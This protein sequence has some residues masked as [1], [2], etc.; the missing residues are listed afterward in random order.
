[1]VSQNFFDALFDK[2]WTPVILLLIVLPAGAGATWWTVWRTDYEMREQLL[3]QARRIVQTVNTRD[4]RAL[5]GT[6]ADLESPTY[7]RLKALLITL[8]QADDRCR[9]IYLMGRQTNGTVFLFVDSE[10]PGSKDYSP[11]G[12]VYDEAGTIEAGVFE[13]GKPIVYGPTKDRWGVWISAYVPIHD[14]R[15]DTVAAMLGIDVDARVWNRDLARAAGMPVATT[16]VLVAILI[17]AAGFASRRRR[18]AAA[19]GPWLQYLEANVVLVAGLVLTLFAAWTAYKIDS[20]HRTHIFENLAESET[21]R[22][23]DAFLDLQHAELEGFARFYENSE[24][25]TK[26]EF[27]R[28]T[29]PLVENSAAYAWGW[30]PAVPAADKEAF[31]QQVRREGFDR[32]EIWELGERGT[33]VATEDREVYFPVLRIARRDGNTDAL[34]FDV[35]SETIR[36]SAMTQ[37]IRTGLCTAT[38]PL[39]LVEEPDDQTAMILFRPVFAAGTEQPLMGFAV[40]IIHLDTLLTCVQD[41]ASVHLTL[42]H[43]GK[44]N[45]I[46]PL[47]SFCDLDPS[48]F[49]AALIVSRPISMHG[50]VLKVVAHPGP[51]F[52]SRYPPYRAAANYF[53]AGLLLTL[54]SLALV[55]RPVQQRRRLEELVSQR[56]AALRKIEARY[57][58]V[59][60]QSRTFTWEIDAEGLYTYVS[61]SVEAILGYRPEELTGQKR[62]FELWP[63]TN[64]DKKWEK[65]LQIRKAKCEFRD[66]ENQAVCRDG[67][68]LWMSTN[69]IPLLDADGNL[70][71]YRGTDSDITHR[72]QFEAERKRLLTES[73]TARAELLNTLEERKRA[74]A[75][76]AR[77]ASAV[78]Q[79][80]EMVVITDSN[81]TICY[82]NP[83]FTRVTGYTREEALGQNPRILKSG[84]HDLAYY[85]QLWDT[86]SG[87]KTW[88]GRLV[89]K[90]KDGT[91]YTE[92]ATISP[93]RDKTGRIV[94]YVAVKRDITEHLKAAQENARLEERLQQMQR[95][96][97]IGRLAGGVAHDFNNMLSV[98]LGYGEELF[99]RLPADD[100]LRENAKQIVQAGQRSATLTGQ[101]LAFS[102]RQTLQPRVLD[103]NALLTNLEPMLRRLIGEDIEIRITCCSDLYLVMADPAQIEHVVVNLA[104]NAQDSMA[105]GGTLMIETAN[106]FLDA[107][108]ALVYGE[109]ASG[110]YAMLSIRDTGC[111]MDRETLAQIFEPFFTT[112]EKGRGTGLG[113]ASAYG[114]TRQSGGQITAESEPGK[115]SVFRIYLPRTLAK[116]TVHPDPPKT[117]SSRGMGEHILVVE[118]EESLRTW[119]V[120]EL[121]ERGYRT[122]EAVDGQ[123]ALRLVQQE[124]LRPDLL[125]TDVIMPGITGTEL[126]TRLRPEHPELKVLF[127]SGYSDDLIR[128]HGV[129]EPGIQFLSK[130]FQRDDLARKVRE[131]LHRRIEPP[132]G[133]RILMIDDEPLFRELIG[134]HCSQ[135]GHEFTGVDAAPAALEALSAREFDVLLLDKNLPGSDGYR[136]LQEIREVGHGLPVILLTGDLASV[137]L[138]TFHALGVI[139]AVEKSGNNKSLLDWIEDRLL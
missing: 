2:I 61:P 82:A 28:F 136:I 30:I 115:G 15:T 3:G 75:E 76:L 31:E 92:D 101:L 73:E 1:M 25:V 23:A 113:L 35:G 53:V 65:A 110:E 60:E 38:P 89:N 135:R 95:V 108:H 13:T 36:R 55:A 88:E 133:K 116:P 81:G 119:V 45:E 127:M 44:Q 48:S 96:E 86:I 43:M 29:T 34:G 90:R 72:K 84:E 16:S 64:C 14:L 70:Q 51:G 91:L 80:D 56:T 10:D 99:E 63:E 123:D 5:S 137:D 66:F 139:H 4:I 37:A 118:D 59:A 114:F 125:L 83:T 112:K 17:V 79:V 50:Q 87:G 98:I 40:A 100:P 109:I 27:I 47:V 21:H 104:I 68:I 39:N 131:A 117:A 111:G 54:L 7:Q 138:P 124:G 105:R 9:F 130:P 103:L 93:V 20:F 6:D 85:R 46:Q 121:A 134:H 8:R 78:E 126:A 57:N 52:M 49:A 24:E 94:N 71:G 102:R 58:E 67:S 129:L 62:Y 33:R 77:L 11:P 132:R 12:Q 32:F 120:R 26:A 74:E 41:K 42:A 97:S 107:Y 19:A 122:S 18:L 69:G 22:M 128:S 106:V